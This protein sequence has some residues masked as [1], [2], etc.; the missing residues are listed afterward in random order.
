MCPR[1]WSHPP[2]TDPTTR[3]PDSATRKR[4]GP[5]STR[6]RSSSGVSVTEGRMPLADQSARTAAASSARA[7][8]MR[9]SKAARDL[10]GAP[11]DDV[12]RDEAVRGLE[13]LDRQAGP[14]GEH[15]ELAVD[16]EHGVRPLD[17]VL[18]L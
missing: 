17:D 14:V 3:P 13:H 2:R 16:D 1:Q 11:V 8:R 5:R 18:E 6:R 12:A 10:L 4:S 7:S 9:T 15:T